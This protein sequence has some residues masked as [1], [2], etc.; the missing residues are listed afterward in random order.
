MTLNP[1]GFKESL[2]NPWQS[3]TIVNKYQVISFYQDSR[4]SLQ[5]IDITDAHVI[6]TLVPAK[7]AYNARVKL[8]NETESVCS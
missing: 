8:Y 5:V 6:I 3:Q 1:S 7:Q 4:A 2:D